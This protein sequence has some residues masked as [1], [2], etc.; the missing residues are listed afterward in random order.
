MRIMVTNDDGIDA[1]G[2]HVL[3]KAMSRHGEVVVIA[4]DED[5]SGASSALGALHLI[6]P[7]V[8]E[9]HMPDVDRAFSVTG[10]PAL[11][12]MFARLGAFGPPPDLVVSGINPGNNVGRSVYHSGTIGAAFTARNGGI[13]GVAISQAVTG[14]GVEGQAWDEMLV[15]QHWDSAAAVAD[16]V[17]EGLLADPPSKP[18]VINVNV[19]DVDIDEIK[20][21]KRAPIGVRP[22]RSMASAV[23]EPR[24]GHEG[25]WTVRMDWGDEIRPHPDTDVGIVMDGYVAVS[26]LS[27]IVDCEA[28]SDKVAAALDSLIG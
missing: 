5:H 11:C 4:P 17:V 9:C 13:S 18:A 2:L 19:P 24:E 20:G 28:E 14:W 1:V 3:A 26:W 8:H 22:P 25:S 15:N 6:K 21:W 7:V 16:K 10:P 27:G 12:V 23:L